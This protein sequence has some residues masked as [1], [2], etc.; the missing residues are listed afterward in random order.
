[1]D[2]DEAIEFLNNDNAHRITKG[3]LYGDNIHCCQ[4]LSKDYKPGDR[5]TP[6][7]SSI[8]LFLSEAEIIRMAAEICDKN[9]WLPCDRIGVIDWML[10]I[11]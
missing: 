8:G 10:S 2:I 4:Y 3:S 5:L 11:E 1:M 9:Q 6:L 7:N